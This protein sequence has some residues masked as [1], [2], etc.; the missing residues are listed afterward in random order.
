MIPT[1]MMTYI[2]HESFMTA[3]NET[4]WTRKQARVQAAESEIN[5]RLRILSED[6]S[7]IPEERQAIAEALIC[8]QILREECSFV[9][10]LA[11]LAQFSVAGLAP[12]SLQSYLK[13]A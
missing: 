7:A 3:V 1:I 8:L 4:D 10:G 2:W 12:L 5:K 13:R 11:G 9:A 6:G